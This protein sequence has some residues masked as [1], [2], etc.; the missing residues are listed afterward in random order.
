VVD[1]HRNSGRFHDTVSNFSA[2]S[3][4]HGGTLITDPPIVSSSG[5][6]SGGEAIGGVPSNGTTVHLTLRF[7]ILIVDLLF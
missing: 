5:T 2:T 1:G 7:V 6:G 4:S 3:D